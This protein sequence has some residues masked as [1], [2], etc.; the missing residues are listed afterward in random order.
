[1]ARPLDCVCV[2]WRDV[3]RVV[4]AAARLSHQPTATAQT[5]LINVPPPSQTFTPGPPRPGKMAGCGSGGY[6][7]MAA[8]RKWLKS[9]SRWPGVKAARKRR[10]EARR[11]GQG[12]AQTQSQS[13]L[14][15]YHTT[16]PDI[17]HPNPHQHTPNWSPVA[18]P[19]RN[20][21]L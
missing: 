3:G 16:R 12:Q 11:Q 10:L 20:L 17:H 1:M 2:M 14:A 5:P 13:R 9:A 19:S 8:G 21:S 6:L 15:I 4:V 18:G 7:A